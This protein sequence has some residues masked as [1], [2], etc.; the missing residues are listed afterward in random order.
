MTLHST[1]VLGWAAMLILTT[2]PVALADRDPTE[3]ERAAIETLLR[4]QGF[5]SWN[6]IEVEDDGLAWEADVEQAR[7]GEGPAEDV[8]VER[9][10]L[11][12]PAGDGPG[13]TEPSV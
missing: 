3:E 2:M 7:R 6:R 10:L 13:Q 9:H 11:E 12:L 4:A 5:E 8:E 1:R